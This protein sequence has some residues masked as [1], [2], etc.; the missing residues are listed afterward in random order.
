MHAARLSRDLRWVL[1]LAFAALPAGLVLGAQ[2]AA[3]GDPTAPP[4]EPAGSGVLAEAPDGEPRQE[5]PAG[6]EI[7]G[8]P[9]RVEPATPP[10]EGLGK[11]E[12]RRLFQAQ[13]LITALSGT[14]VFK[15]GETPR[16]VWRDVETVQRLGGDTRLR[17]RWFN[18]ELDEF[19]APNDSGRWLA[20]VE[21]TAPNGT[22]FRRGLTFYGLPQG[23]P[24]EYSPD[25]TIALPHFPG[26]KAPAVLQEH[27]AEVL[28][29]ANKLLPHSVLD[30]E[31]GAILLAGL[32]E[33]KPLGRAARFVDSAAVLHE[34]DHLALKLKLQGLQA[35]VRPLEPPRRRDRPATILHAGSLAEA[36]MAADAKAQIDA[37]CRAWVEDT[38]EP[39]VTLVARRGV[40]VTHEAFGLDPSGQPIT[41]DYRCWT[42]SITKTVTALLFSQ[43]VDQR[44]VAW[45]DP[46]SA[47]FPDYPRNDPRVPT[48]RQCFNHTSGLTGHGEFGGMRNPH[49]ENIILNGIDVNEP[50]A[51]YAYSGQGFELAAKAME[52]L[53][54][55]SAVRIYEEHLF[56]PLGFGDVPMGNASSDGELTALELATL[57]QWV[58]NRGSY[59][60]L[61]FIRPATFDG[62][63][64]Q[65]LRVAD[66]DSIEGQ[67]LGLHSIRHAKPGAPPDSRRAE[68][69]LFSPSTIGHGSF[70]GCIFVVDPEQQLIITQVRKQSGPRSAEWSARFFQTIAAA[71]E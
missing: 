32:A 9:A 65:P 13:E 58:A 39:L 1:V 18:A 21:G 23:L 6:P 29:L 52:L 10:S 24:T 25:L 71:V 2:V 20:W 30:S 16:I 36:G 28:A 66:Q 67:G 48:F 37:V 49:L 44:L 56:R 54:G 4:G 33:F 68:D 11:P 70:S 27:Q 31:H 47:V 5:A 19:P 14:W 7:R 51:K 64:P 40:I 69:L 43:F 3:A 50:G 46:L 42:A 15:P 61:E 60:D 53:T 38:G 12:A 57:A 63:L 62:L 41:R 26:P 35:R 45:D 8:E 34:D 55:K 17:V 22:P 59:G